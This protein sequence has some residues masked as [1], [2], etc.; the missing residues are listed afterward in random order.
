IDPS[1]QTFVAAA[2]KH[3]VMSGKTNNL[4]DPK[5]NVTRGEMAAIVARL[6]ENGKINPSPDK[7][8]IGKL[9]TVDV[10]GKKITVTK[11]GQSKTYSLDADALCY[12]DG[13]RTGIGVFKANE[14]VKVALDAA[15]K[16]TVMAYTTATTT[17]PPSVSVATTYTGTIRSLLS[18]NPITLSFQ[19]DSGTL[20]SYPLSSNA[21]IKQNGIVKDLTALTS[22]S[23][24]EI[25][26]TGDSVTEVNLLSAV[27]SGNEKRGYVVNMYL[28]Y[29]TIRYDDGTSEEI[30]KT[31]AG[32]S[33]S[34]L[35]RGQRVAVTKSGSL[36]TG[37]V[38][39]SE[40]K[41]L[42]GEVVSVGSSS[43]TIE[44]VDGYER[45]IDMASSYKVK[46]EDGDTID[47]DEINEED[48]VEIEVNS[49]EEAVTIKLLD[50]SSSSSSSSNLEGEVTVL[51]TSGDY[52]IK[53]R[54]PDGSEKTYDVED[55]VDVY[56]DGDS[57]DFDDI[58]KGDYVK[59]KLNSRD[60]VTRIDILDVELVEGEVTDVDT[61][62][63]WSITIEDSRGDDE[64]YDVSDDVD[65]YDEDGKSKKF[66]DIDDGDQVKLVID[67]DDEV[68]TITIL[69][70]D[71]SSSRD[72]TYTGTL[73][74]LDEDDEELTLK[75][76]SGTKTYT[77]AR[78]VDVENDGDELDLDEILIGSKV[79]ITV[80]DGEVEEIE[81]TDAEDITIEGK[82]YNIDAH[83][84]WLK[85]ENGTHKLK[86][87]SD[88]TLEDDEGD[89]VDWDE[90]KDDFLNDD[91]EVELDNGEV[92]TLTV[93][94]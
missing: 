14:N 93:I 57:I 40:A 78:N 19:P 64:T 41:K 48:E 51:D 56:E 70:E 35:F 38:G 60:D 32:A 58:R 10:T 92:E 87:A 84:I 17:A 46:D 37:V 71:S 79:R 36:V 39:L 5:A 33:F 23:R 52:S 66:K 59:L 69:D 25:K 20:N 90:L 3:G 15:N 54:K 42:F 12:R 62:G 7:Y 22:G 9:S 88:V 73:T 26:V 11:D 34:Q 6:F 63:S 55:D 50:G 47:L 77:L 74:G 16:V 2:V 89:E 21:I 44:D 72:G 1:M 27:P 49:K 86:M 31:N 61:S 76:S 4:F 67:D 53:I 43:I 94:E 45:N 30:Q 29:F 80:E 83:Y 75:T 91:V 65:V 13:K 24:A 81:I 82:L 18:G 28:D 8:F 85:Q 68:I